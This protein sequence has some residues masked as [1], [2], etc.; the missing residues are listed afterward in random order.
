MKSILILILLV[1]SFSSQANFLSNIGNGLRDFFS[2]LSGDNKRSQQTHP[3]G[4]QSDNDFCPDQVA[5]QSEVLD[6]SE[7]EGSGFTNV[8]N[9]EYSPEYNRN[10]HFTHEFDLNTIVLKD[11]NWDPEKARKQIDRAA[12]VFEQCG[13]KINK[14]KMTF[15]NSPTGDANFPRSSEGGSSMEQNALR[16]RVDQFAAA[17]PIQE[18]PVVVFA[19]NTGNNFG[20]AQFSSTFA[21]NQRDLNDPRFDS[22]QS[23]SLNYTFISG[24]ARMGNNWY[25]TVAHEVAHLLCQCGHS[26]N[27]TNLLNTQARI[28]SGD[29][30]RLSQSQCDVMKRSPMLRRTNS[31][32]GP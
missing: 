14:V 13:I 12:R 3:L 4:M 25:S 31:V 11:S 18:R 32:M 9:F 20:Y 6:N 5:P 26:D 10:Q 24:N 28:L 17:S 7:W 23:P 16:R 21:N 30:E 1:F 19:E 22:S 27:E 15:A 8:E 29:R 2:F